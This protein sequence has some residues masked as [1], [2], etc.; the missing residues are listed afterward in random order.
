[1]STAPS[2][3]SSTSAKRRTSRARPGA[4]AGVAPAAAAIAACLLA[5]SAPARAAVVEEIVAKV[6]NR[7]I[8]A[9]EYAERQKALFAQIMQE[10]QGADQEAEL[11]DAQDSLLANVIT[12]ALLL[13][14]AANIFDMDRIRGSLVDDF[15]KQQNILSDTE[16]DAALKDQG[17]TRKEL[18]DHLIRLAV[19]NEIIN[20][21]VKRK[22]SVSETEIK[23]W[24][25]AHQAQFM[26]QET[27]TLREIVFLYTPDERDATLANAR[28]VAEQARGGADFKDLVLKHS[29]AGTRETEG[30]LGPIPVADLQQDLAKAARGLQPGMVSDPI[31]TGRSFHVIRLEA[32]VPAGMKT[33]TDVHDDVRNAVRDE[34]F[35]PRFDNYLK[36]LWKENHIEVSPKYQAQLVVT[37]LNA[38]PST[39]PAAAPSTAP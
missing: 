33:I 34:K 1:M 5:A 37:P 23:A 7:V 20:Y 9:S 35:R 8:T 10:H 12:E 30:M 32:R 18:E 38:K 6:N 39:S 21:D 26:T 15:R 25:D 24:Y 31:D 13:E 27:V 4:I 19:P 11:K 28:S 2:S 29:E 17:M 22:I 36:R 3:P 14:R 16:L